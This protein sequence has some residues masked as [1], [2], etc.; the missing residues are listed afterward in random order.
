MSSTR[1][2]ALA[3]AALALGAAGCGGSKKSSSQTEAATTSASQTQTTTTPTSTS[4]TTN[5]VTPPGGA[6]GTAFVA[7]ADL[8]CHRVNIKRAS[9]RITTAATIVR[10]VPQLAAYERAAYAELGKLTPP[11]AMVDDWKKLVSAAETYARDS[12]KVATSLQ[13]RNLKLAGSQL[14]SASTAQSHMLAIAK[15]NG[16]TDCAQAS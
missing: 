11:A 3:L 5:T 6:E 12:G 9:T 4:T 16:F 13:A 15:R 10:L 1:F 8:I 7:K 2:A 14:A